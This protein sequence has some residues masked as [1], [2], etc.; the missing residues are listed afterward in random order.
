MSAFSFAQTSIFEEHFT[1]APSGSQ[2]GSS[3]NTPISANALDTCTDNP[4]W[5]GTKVYGANGAIR[6]ATA[7]A[8]G[9]LISPEINFPENE[10]TLSFK[11]TSWRTT[12]S[13]WIRVFVVNGTEATEYR[14]DGVRSD[15]VFGWSTHYLTISGCTEGTKI[16]FASASAEKGRFFIDDVVILPIN[17]TTFSISGD[18]FANVMPNETVTGNFTI[19]GAGC[20]ANSY[21]ISV[22][23]PFAVTPTSLTSA[24]LEA[25]AAITVS[26]TPTAEGE[27]STDVTIIANTDTFTA[28]TI[29]GTC[30]VI[31]SIATIAELRALYDL[32]V[33]ANVQGTT[34]YKY[35]GEAIVTSAQKGSGYHYATIQDETGA[36][37]VFHQFGDFFANLVAGSKI[38]NL[39]GTLTNYFQL[40]EFIPTKADC[41]IVTPFVD[42]AEIEALYTEVALADFSDWAAISALQSK[43][44]RLPNIQFIAPGT[45]E[46]DQKY[47]VTDGSTMDS[48]IYCLYRNADY[49]GTP[50]VANQDITVNGFC[51]MFSKS[52][53][54]R[55]Y[56][57]VPIT[58]DGV[59][60]IDDN[61]VNQQ[62]SI[63]PNPIND[64]FTIDGVVAERVEMFNLLGTKVL[65]VENP[66]NV[67]A[68]NHLS[69][70]LYIVKIYT[71]EGVAVKKVAKN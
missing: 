40:A 3:S 4:G 20:T 62:V 12:D 49:I 71:N 64:H 61:A 38:T 10:A 51:H 8:A 39:Y 45:L 47:L 27:Y 68:T 2:W 42:D 1:T 70:G 29:T 46:A 52:N 7:S 48:A 6:I 66:S 22:D 65:S 17:A 37:M 30:V 31:E 57:I 21:T 54:P 24:E 59:V 23:A 19:L 15:E 25:G 41:E 26:F 43:L 16:K 63:Y 14:V 53:K 35:T 11:A 13:T 55:H 34:V 9:E 60:A 44:V 36:I 32:T 33:E 28:G 67:I 50:I 5:T 18:N 58:F 69:N 56:T